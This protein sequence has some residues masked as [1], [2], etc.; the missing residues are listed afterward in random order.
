MPALHRG[1]DRIATP[2]A[3]LVCG[4]GF[5]LRDG[6]FRLLGGKEVVRIPSSVQTRRRRPDAFGGP[7]GQEGSFRW[8]N[9][10]EGF[11]YSRNSRKEQELETSNVVLYSVV[12]R[13]S[14]SKEK[15]LEGMLLARK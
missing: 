14:S 11:S 15:E 12:A 2:I 1:G 3:P 9:A 13:S 5:S 4:R 7:L 8:L 10:I 6:D